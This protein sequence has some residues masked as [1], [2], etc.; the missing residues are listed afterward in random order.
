MPYNDDHLKQL[1]CNNILGIWRYDTTDNVEE[2]FRPDYFNLA[3]KRLRKA[4]VIVIISTREEG[5]QKRGAVVSE[6]TGT[7]IVINLLEEVTGNFCVNCRWFVRKYTGRY[8]ILFDMCRREPIRLNVVEGTPILRRAH[9]ERSSTDSED[10]GFEGRYYEE[11]EV[12]IQE[13]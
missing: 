7:H 4:D 1:T 8:A 12:D 3:A 11:L 6:R 10:C 5:V 13:S 9:E 2:P